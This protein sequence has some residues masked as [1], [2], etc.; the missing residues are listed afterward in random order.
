[1]RKM[2]GEFREFVSKGSALDL[3][4]GIVIG[5]AFTAVVKA[6]VD[7]LIMPLVSLLLGRIDFINMYVTLQ[8]GTP[9]GPY[10]TLAAAQAAGAVT[11][12]YGLVINALVSFLL[13]AW[14]VFLV[15]KVANRFR[16]A[17]DPTHRP[18]PYC[19]S[20]VPCAATRCPA[21]TSELPAPE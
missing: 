16:R 21:C 17:Q 10:P 12:S 19:L 3:A 11:L 6:I 20:D 18:C 9:A 14:V 4:V 8:P 1:M 2:I 5:A 13:V 15:V 7:G